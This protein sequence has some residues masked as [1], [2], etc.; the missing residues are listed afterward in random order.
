MRGR[1]WKQEPEDDPIKTTT[2]AML[3]L[4]RA[5]PSTGM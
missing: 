4:Q 2:F 1:G 5:A 3:V